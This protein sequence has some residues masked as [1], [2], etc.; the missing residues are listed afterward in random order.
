MVLRIETHDPCSFILRPKET[1]VS[2]RRKAYSKEKIDEWR[3]A[4]KIF[5]QDGNGQISLKELGVVLEQLG[6]TFLLRKFHNIFF[7]CQNIILCL[8]RLRLDTACVGKKATDEELR[9]IIA[10]VDKDKS[11]TID[12]NEFCDM[13]AK[14]ETTIP[15]AELREVFNLFD[16]FHSKP[17]C[18]IPKLTLLLQR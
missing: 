15:E 3:E 14:Q 11:G 10:E 5:D 6:N 18:F 1:I 9:D 2:P 8:L 17:F 12:F 16:R 4:F 7:Q 13:M